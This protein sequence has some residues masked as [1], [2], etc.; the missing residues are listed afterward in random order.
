MLKKA[1]LIPVLVLSL[2]TS[3]IS[4]H[5]VAGATEFTQYK[6][7]LDEAQKRKKQFD[8][9]VNQNLTLEA[10][11]KRLA[12]FKDDQLRAL[13]KKDPERFKRMGRTLDNLTQSIKNVASIESVMSAKI[14]GYSTTKLSAALAEQYKAGLDR[15]NQKLDRAIEGNDIMTNVKTTGDRLNAIMDNLGRVESPTQ[16]VQLAVEAVQGIN[17]TTA[18]LETAYASAKT[19]KMLE[20]AQAMAEEKISKA[21]QK[22]LAEKAEKDMRAIDKMA[23][24]K[25]PTNYKKVR[26]EYFRKN[27]DKIPPSMRGRINVK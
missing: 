21:K 19:D 10:Q 23:Q 11:L 4:G 5:S 24:R 26:E 16:A 12:T 8:T 27:P 18:D 17:Q 7:Y 15:A 2:N 22:Q 25:A 3:M 6:R 13:W 9:W 20:K 1:I 14:E